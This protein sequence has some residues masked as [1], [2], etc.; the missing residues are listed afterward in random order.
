MY[1]KAEKINTYSRVKK[2]TIPVA[3][4]PQRKSNLYLYCHILI[5]FKAVGVK[6][7]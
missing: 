1:F 5:S 3:H 6:T 7:V 2:K 4:N